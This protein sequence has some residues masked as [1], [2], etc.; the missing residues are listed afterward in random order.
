MDIQMDIGLDCIFP[1]STI[2][3]GANRQIAW[4]TRTEAIK[5]DRS[6]E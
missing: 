3:L 6:G 2:D 4:K 5:D 1:R